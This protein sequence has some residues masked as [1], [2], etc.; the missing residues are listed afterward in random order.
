MN[1]PYVI[2][3]VFNAP[4]SK[5]WYAIT[6]AYEMKKWYFDL[7]GFTPEVGYTFSFFGGHEDGIQYK[8]LCR[9][10]CAIENERLSYTWSYEGYPGESEVVFELFAEGKQTRLKLTHIGLDTFDPGNKDFAASNF[11]SGWEYIISTSLD[12]YLNK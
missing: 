11:A 6:N 4:A 7:P 5:V 2:E 3:R 12:G 9:V 1:A 10:T 8:H